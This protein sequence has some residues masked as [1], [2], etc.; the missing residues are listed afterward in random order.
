MKTFGPVDE[1]SAA[2]LARCL[3]AEPGALGVLCADHHL[4]Y[5]MPIGGVVAYRGLVSPSAVG[6]DIGCGNMAVRTDALASEV[7]VPTVMRDIASHVS[8]GMGRNNQEAVDHPVLDELRTSPV[9]VQRSG[10]QKAAAQ[11]GTVGSGN[12]YVDLFVDEA[13]GALWVGVHF[14]SRGIG[15]MTASWALEKA[16]ASS[17]DMDAP[18]CVIPTASELGQD[19]FV[20]MEIAGRYAYAGREWVV[21][22]VLRILGARPLMTVHNHHNYAWVER[23]GG[24]DW[25]VHRKG[26]TPAFPDQL[27]FVGGTMGDNAV[28]LAGV[29]SLDSAAAL[30]STVHG[31][32]R[33]MS[34]TQ[35][36]GKVKVTKQWGCMNYRTC[37][38]LAPA[39]D[40]R[41]GRNGERPE[42]PA[43]GGKLDLRVHREKVREGLIDWAAA[44]AQLASQ[45]IVLVGAGADEAPGA[46]KRLSEVLGYH[47]GTIEILHQLRPIGVA[48]AGPDVRDDYKD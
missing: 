3:E 37:T 2:Q 39:R 33:A 46:Y 43:C 30:Y 11:L 8:F 40:F 18:P 5:S 22:R 26:A 36:A 31:A 48:M 45:G 42:C 4:G 21:N 35:A 38:F 25:F 24:E 6:Y 14:G 19:Y 16:G 28:I 9:G 47:A 29:E 17:N 7:D 20:G 1:R 44:Q 13:D 12:H 32:G 10:V 34:R 23:H 41:R 15:H 27:G